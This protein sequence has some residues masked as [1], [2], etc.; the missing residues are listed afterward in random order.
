MRA[1]IPRWLLATLGGLVAT[2]GARAEDSVALE[3]VDVE[4]DTTWSG[5]VRLVR[6]IRV[7]AHATLRIAAGTR[8]TV[9]WVESGGVESHD[10]P[11]IEVFGRLVAEGDVRAPIRFEPEAMPATSKPVRWKRWRGIL[12]H[13]AV[14]AGVQLVRCL[15]S[16]AETGFQPGCPHAVARDCAF[17][18]CH[19]GIGAGVL[20]GREDQVIRMVGDVAPTI[21]GCRFGHCEVGISVELA[22]RP[23]VHRCVFVRCGS[24]IANDRHSTTYPVKGLGP[25]VDRCEFIRCKLAV[26]GPARVANSVFEGNQL[27]FAGSDFGEFSL[28]SIDAFVRGRNLFWANTALVRSDV[29]LGADALLADPKRRRA[30]PETWNGDALLGS[31]DQVL[32]LSPGSP[33]LGAAGDGG[34]LGAFGAE[35][36]VRADTARVSDGPGL[37]VEEWLHLGPGASDADSLA[38]LATEVL[39]RPRFAGEVDGDGQWAV[40]E[41]RPL[42]DP[43]DSRRILAAIPK[44]RTLL[45]TLSSETEKDVSLRFGWDGVLRAWWNGIPLEVPAGTRRFRADDASIVVHRRKGPNTLLLRHLPRMSTG[46]LAVRI[47]DAGAD[48]VP[49][50]LAL[51]AIPVTGKPP[52]PTPIARVSWS[53]ER[54]A[55]GKPSGR[56]ILTVVLATP[57]HWR[58]AGDLR[59]MALLDA[60]G[61]PVE[62]SGTKLVFGPKAGSIVLTLAR[63]LSTG[64]WRLRVNDWRRPSGEPFAPSPIEVTFRVP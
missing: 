64:T 44:P 19:T 34:D 16:G 36:T 62:L 50:G 63:P 31:L 6:P 5:Q 28:A 49:E 8:I 15:V 39:R 43:V 41:G 48:R 58:D 33:A 38:D 17:V 7:Q 25:F 35:G 46:R 9:P 57:V 47:V 23:F 14:P 1:A 52:G 59:H 29:L 11:G 4:R 37:V 18:D 42:A 45:A 60:G 10:K 56:G 12:V 24:G 13:D 32:G 40:L 26:G 3:A 21:D 51:A 20:W 22:A 54:A 55:G 2:S 53:I 27:V 30:L 61:T